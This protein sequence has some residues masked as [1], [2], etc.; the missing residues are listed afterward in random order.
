[1]QVNLI[2]HVK[3]MSPVAVIAISIVLIIVATKIVN[4]LRSKGGKFPFRA[5]PLEERYS[6]ALEATKPKQSFW[7]RVST[8][9]YHPTEWMTRNK[10]VF[11]SYDLPSTT[12]SLCAL[13][14]KL[15]FRPARLGTAGEICEAVVLCEF[16]MEAG[17]DPFGDPNVSVSVNQIRLVR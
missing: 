9:C 17:Y 6:E 8:N 1:M 5:T 13:S 16:I 10:R 7:N 12:Q 14:K 2:S 11:D 15:M 3:N 4:W